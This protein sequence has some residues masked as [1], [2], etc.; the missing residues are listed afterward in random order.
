MFTPP[1]P[2]RGTAPSHHHLALNA[3]PTGSGGLLTAM[4]SG[5]CPSIVKTLLSCSEN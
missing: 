2:E 4:A 3:G 1:C 5:H